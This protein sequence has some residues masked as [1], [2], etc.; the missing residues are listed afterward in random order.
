MGRGRGRETGR[1]REREREVEM[2]GEGTLTK[3]A[4][5][6]TLTACSDIRHL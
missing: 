2:C 5:G 4:L 6:T 1:E 3:I